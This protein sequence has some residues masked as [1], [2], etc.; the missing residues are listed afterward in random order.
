[1]NQKTGTQAISPLKMETK[2][3]QPQKR[4]ER[5][6]ELGMIERIVMGGCGCM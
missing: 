1:M 5:V 2:H 3:K 6:N 4:L